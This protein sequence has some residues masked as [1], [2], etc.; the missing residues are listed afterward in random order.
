MKKVIDVSLGEDEKT[1]RFLRQDE[2]KGVT[3]QRRLNYIFT[4]GKAM[5]LEDGEAFALTGK[6]D[7]LKLVD[8]KHDE[9]GIEDDL[10]ETGGNQ[11]RHIAAT[12]GIDVFGCK[13]AEL[14]F[15]I[16]KARRNGVKPKDE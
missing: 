8:K 11:I 9:L 3:P 5:S 13:T 1:S 7:C 2:F 15:K 14:K 16:R 4:G 6:Y 12:Y 10:D